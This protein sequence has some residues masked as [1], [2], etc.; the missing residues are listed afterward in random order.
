[1]VETPFTL[2][3]IG[4]LAALA[5]GVIPADERDAGAATV[6][7][8]A[9]IAERARHGVNGPLYA[10]GLKAAAGLAAA[11]FGRSV[12]ELNPNE[13]RQLLDTLAQESPAFFRQLRADTCALYLSD[14]AVWQ[15]IGFPG[16]S[17]ERGGYPD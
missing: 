13:V 2:D 8:G 9:G 10:E 1:M 4:A 16:P 14:P 11:K 17:V 12:R 3:E 6:H 7:A 5:N 15:R